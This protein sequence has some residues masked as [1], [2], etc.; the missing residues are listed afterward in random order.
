MRDRES[1]GPGWGEG[2][3]VL[4]KNNVQID[5]TDEN[6]GGNGVK[7]SHTFTFSDGDEISL[8]D[9]GDNAVLWVGSITFSCPAHSPP[10]KRTL[11]RYRMK[12][13]RSWGRRDL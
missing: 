7:K 11:D 1:F 12:G 8:K 6:T 5:E 13:R 2:K 3:A 10:V 4:Y 9:E